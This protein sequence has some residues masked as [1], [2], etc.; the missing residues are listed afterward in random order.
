MKKLPIPV[1]PKAESSYFQQRDDRA[2]PKCKR[3][4]VMHP[5]DAM[6]CDS[7]FSD[8]VICEDCGQ[9]EAFE[10]LRGRAA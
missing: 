6:N 8:E 5:D 7:R 1:I 3:K 9:A 4:G 2:C 10:D